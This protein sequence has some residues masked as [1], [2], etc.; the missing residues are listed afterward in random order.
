M[1]AKRF[2]A[3]NL[4]NAMEAIGEKAVA[5]NRSYA[6]DPA[7]RKRVYDVARFGNA[8]IGAARGALKGHRPGAYEDLTPEELKKRK[9]RDR[10]LGAL[11][12]ALRGYSD[13]H[14]LGG[15]EQIV[16]GFGGKIGGVAET[17]DGR[18]SESYTRLPPHSVARHRR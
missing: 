10:G 13:G 7:L 1:S 15:G 8:A 2:V 17:D 6:A 16:G 5:L 9:T 3:H 14:I 4:F 11:A 18:V 12:G